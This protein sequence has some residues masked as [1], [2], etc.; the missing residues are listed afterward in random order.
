MPFVNSLSLPIQT[1]IAIAIDT[2]CKEIVSK[3][4]SVKR[5]DLEKSDSK[6]DESKWKARVLNSEVVLN[7]P[8]H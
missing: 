7:A 6:M 3:A 5:F 2:D 4:L 8:T 1:A